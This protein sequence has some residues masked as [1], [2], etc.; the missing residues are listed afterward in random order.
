M[1]DNLQS[2]VLQVVIP[3]LP[4]DELSELSCLAT[5]AFHKP[6]RNSPQETPMM[7]LKGLHP[8]WRDAYHAYFKQL[9]DDFREKNS[10]KSI[11]ILTA[12]HEIKRATSSTYKA[13]WKSKIK[14]NQGVDMITHSWIAVSISIDPVL[15]AS[16]GLKNGMDEVCWNCGKMSACVELFRCARCHKARYCSV[17]CQ[18][19]AWW[20]HKAT[21]TQEYK[22]A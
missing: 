20:H 11:S 17:E 1:H 7:Q 18:K 3:R 10:E 8:T 13:I 14:Q 16:I 12:I 9:S 4:E 21:G 19:D 15:F 5:L 22:C 6:W 2:S